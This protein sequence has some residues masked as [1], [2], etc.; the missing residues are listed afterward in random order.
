MSSWFTTVS[1]TQAVGT[2]RLDIVGGDMVVVMFG[3]LD[4]LE[5]FARQVLTNVRDAGDPR[6]SAPP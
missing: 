6:R 3:T 1:K 2:Y 5:Q 4:E